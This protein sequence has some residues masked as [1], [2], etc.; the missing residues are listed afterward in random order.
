MDQQI[1][2]AYCDKDTREF[3]FKLEKIFHGFMKN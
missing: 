2:S 3:L 1:E